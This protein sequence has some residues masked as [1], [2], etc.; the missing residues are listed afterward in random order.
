[1]LETDLAHQIVDFG[2]PLFEQGTENCNLI[3]NMPELFP[4]ILVGVK[5]NLQLVVS[6]NIYENLII[7]KKCFV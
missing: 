7:I 6:K 3:T 2:I 4:L 5:L 1:M